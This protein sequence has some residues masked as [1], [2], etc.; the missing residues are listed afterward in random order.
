MYST[1]VI[2]VE[3]VDLQ[4]RISVAMSNHELPFVT[5]SAILENPDRIHVT[6]NTRDEEL[7]NRLKAY[8]TADVTLEIEY[9]SGTA[10][11]E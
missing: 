6:V 11:E 2:G 4:N 9:V 5:S 3:I 7:L 10:V 8:N 1:R